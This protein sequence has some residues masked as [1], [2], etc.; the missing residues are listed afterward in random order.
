MREIFTRQLKEM[1]EQK[2]SSDLNF[3][4]QIMFYD[5]IPHRLT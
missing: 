5:L 2:I 3:L 4:R 1:K